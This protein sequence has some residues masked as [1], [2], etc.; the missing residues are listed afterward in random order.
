[1]RPPPNR[2]RQSQ[3]K[4]KQRWSNKGPLEGEKEKGRKGRRKKEGEK[5]ERGEKQEVAEQKRKEVE[6]VAETVRAG[7]VRDI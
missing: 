4:S 3:S 7:T 2:S 6:Q 5:K 1:M